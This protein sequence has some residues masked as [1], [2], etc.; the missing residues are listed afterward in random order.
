MICERG[1]NTKYGGG[2]RCEVLDVVVGEASLRRWRSREVLEER[3]SHADIW[4]E[5]LGRERVY[6]R[7]A[8]EASVA[9]AE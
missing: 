4:A 9:K 3:G 6:L 5:R 2:E 1:E 8:E 7:S